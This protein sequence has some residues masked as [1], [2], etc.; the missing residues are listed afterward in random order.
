MTK[1]NWPKSLGKNHEKMP[2]FTKFYDFLG[3]IFFVIFGYTSK[4]KFLVYVLVLLHTSRK[5]F[6]M[7]TQND[8]KNKNLVKK[9]E[10]MH[11]FTIFLDFWV[12]IFLSFWVSQKKNKNRPGQQSQ[13]IH[14]KNF[15]HHR[16]ITL[17]KIWILWPA[18]KKNLDFFCWEGSNLSWHFIRNM[19]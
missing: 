7:V 15:H 18:P 2:I 5:F 13:N 16:F 8:R 19:S 17:E 3:S 6:W 9:C 12:N 11:F 1:K 14:Q 10:K 4:K